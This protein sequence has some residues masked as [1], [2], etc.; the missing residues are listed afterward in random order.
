MDKRYDFVI[1][2]AGKAGVTAAQTLREKLPSSSILLINGEDR[3]PYKRTNLTKHLNDS[4]GRDD[5]ALLSDNDYE[6]LNLERIDGA[7]VFRINPEEKTL[8]LRSAERVRWDRLLLAT[9]AVPNRLDIP[10]SEFIHHLRNIDE[11]E[12]IRSLLKDHPRTVVIGQGVEGVELAEQ[13]CIAD[14]EVLLIGREDRLMGRWLDP[15]LSGRMEDLL[16]GR[17]IQ[18]RYNLLP[19]SVSRSE[20]SFILNCGV[21]DVE[22]DLIISSLGIKGNPYLAEDLGIYGSTGIVIDRQCRTSVPDIFAAGDVTQSDPGW[23]RGLWHWAEFQ[24]KTAALN[25]AA[26]AV[27]TLLDGPELYNRPT[28]LK[29]EPF[30]DFYFSMAL[31]EVKDSDDSYV[32]VDNETRYLRIFERDGKSIAALMQG[33]G[34][35]GGKALE[36]AVQEGLN[37]DDASAK[38]MASQTA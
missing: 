3:L 35:A 20:D 10:G 5:F 6:T 32:F 15:A 28:R 14:S 21:E 29:C 9:G 16:Q 27:G 13:C 19:L 25:M 7:R 1:V 23:P 4:F 33:Y 8:N 34:K 31:D 12:E 18:C 30:G 38:L 36:K 26:S 37:A 2:G 22:T 24:G 11:A 17:G